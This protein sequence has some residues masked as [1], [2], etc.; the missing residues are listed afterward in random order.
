M[1]PWDGGMTVTEDTLQ[2]RPRAP[3]TPGGTPAI[4]DEIA[5][6]LEPSQARM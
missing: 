6:G 1:I 2:V 3:N 5:P 4:D